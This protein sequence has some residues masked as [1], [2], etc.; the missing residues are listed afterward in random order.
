MEKW[1]QFIFAYRFFLFLTAMSI[2]D[3][4]V[5][6][7]SDPGR[8]A[9]VSSHRLGCSLVAAMLFTLLLHVVLVGHTI[10]LK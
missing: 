3:F 8:K 1:Q 6:D 2:S 5:V 9:K 10:Q 4:Q 7:I